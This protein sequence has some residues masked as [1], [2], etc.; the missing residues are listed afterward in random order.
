MA[1]QAKE[2]LHGC[3]L[4]YLF[5]FFKVRIFKCSYR[6]GL[7]EVAEPPLGLYAGNLQVLERLLNPIA[8]P[9]L[10]LYVGNLQ[11]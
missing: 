5:V 3:S 7:M 2:N 1:G 4:K 11:V 6:T 8:E 10:G 9:P